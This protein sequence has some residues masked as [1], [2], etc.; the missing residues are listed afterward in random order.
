MDTTCFGR[1]WGVLWS[2][3]TLAA[4][5]ALTVVAIERE[6]NALYMQAL[7]LLREKGVVIQSIICDR[8]SG[9]L[10]AFLGIPAQMCRF[11]QIKIIVRHLSRK[12]KS[13]AAQALRALSLTLTETT[14][15]AFEAALKCWYEQYAAFLNERSVNEK[16]GHSRYT[17]RRLRA[18]YNRLKRHLPWLFTCERFPNLGIPNT[19]NLLEGRFSEIKPLLRRHRGLKKESNFWF[20]KDYFAKNPP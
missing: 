1:K 14:Q 10:Q 8:R 20:I 12:P 15:A 2:S 6:T 9:L 18:A 13:R 17:H 4:S 7:A 11:H 5:A 16:T 19:T 3:M